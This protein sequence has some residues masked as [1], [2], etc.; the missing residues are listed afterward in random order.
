MSLDGIATQRGLG[1]LVAWGL[2]C[3]SDPGQGI[4]LCKEPAPQ[5][6]ALREA[7]RHLRP[8]GRG[9]ARIFPDEDRMGQPDPRETRLAAAMDLS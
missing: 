6:V 2:Q 7:S 3:S 5:S 8:K 9:R 1:R 4:P